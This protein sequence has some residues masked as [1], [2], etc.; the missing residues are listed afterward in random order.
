MRF[1]FGGVIKKYIFPVISSKETTNF[2]FLPYATNFMDQMHCVFF[3]FTGID[4]PS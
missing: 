4:Q 3:S 2:D 1:K